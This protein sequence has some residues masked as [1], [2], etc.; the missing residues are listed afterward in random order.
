M[1]AGK[2]NRGRVPVICST[3]DRLWN[4]KFEG[5]DLEGDSLRSFLHTMLSV[6]NKFD[7]TNLSY[8]SLR[9]K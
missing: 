5:K 3:N 9:I 1:V 2:G 8:T 7:F 6:S 4:A